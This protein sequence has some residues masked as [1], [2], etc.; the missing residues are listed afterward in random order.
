MSHLFPRTFLCIKVELCHIPA[1]PIP[2]AVIS[3]KAGMA[4]YDS[5]LGRNEIRLLI[6]LPGQPGDDVKCDLQTVS[7]DNKPMFEAL[8]YVWG[9]DKDSV[10]IVVQRRQWQIKPNLD[11]ALRA[12]RHSREERRLWI[13]ALCI[14]QSNMN[15][16]S[17]QIALMGTIYC[18]AL[19]VI[20]WL[21]PSTAEIELYTAWLQ[22]DATWTPDES[23]VKLLESGSRCVFVSIS[24]SAVSHSS[25]GQAI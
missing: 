6:L 3:F 23:A 11:M 9:N 10:P 18:T 20:A 14:D 5:P 17:D 2:S 1:H 15:E 25:T 13:D 4:P 22:N 8:S 16:K 12:L 24:S 19:R 21:G 7:L